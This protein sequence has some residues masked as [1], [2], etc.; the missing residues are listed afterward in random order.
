MSKST[1]RVNVKKKH[2]IRDTFFRRA[3]LIVIHPL[4]GA[5]EKGQKWAGLALNLF[6][7]V[8]RFCE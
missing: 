2:N 8:V 5:G 1:P 4:P 6:L 7:A 3:L